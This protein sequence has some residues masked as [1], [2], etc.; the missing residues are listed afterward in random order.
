MKQQQAGVF[1]RQGLAF[2]WRKRGDFISLLQSVGSAGGKAGA[3]RL[4]R[5]CLAETEGD[6]AVDV[7]KLIEKAREAAERRNYDY[8][9]DLYL[10]ALKLAPDTGVARRE[11][12]AVENRQAKEKGTSMWGKAKTAGMIAQ[13]HALYTCKKYDSA[14]EKAEDALKV[15]PSNISAMMLLGKAALDAGYSDSA[16]TTFEDIKAMNAGGNQKQLT[17]ALRELAHAYEAKGRIKEAMDTWGSVMKLSPGDREGS[18]KIRDLS[19]KTMTA[20]IETSA[21]SGRAGAVARATQSEE[22]KAQTDR[23]DR[24][25]GIDIKTAEDLKAV[26]DDTKS[27]IEKRPDDARLWAKLGDLHKQG[28]SY[29]DAKKAFEMAREKDPNNPSW[30][31]RSHDLEIWKMEG[32]IRALN[33]KLKAGDAGVKPQLHKDQLALLEYKL[34][35]FLEREKQYSTESRIR[36]EL[37]VVYYQLAQVKNDRTL[38][39]ECIKRFQFTFQDPK[40][41]RE[42]GLRMGRAFSAKAQYE[43]ALK[44]F[45]ETLR[46]SELKDA[47]WKD[48][49]YEKGDTLQKSG[50]REEARRVFTEIY[51]IDVSYKD[52][53]KRVEDLGQTV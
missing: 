53:S 52:V 49:M 2:D 22:Q 50:Q 40:Y 9:I 47:M 35:S 23:L 1:G 12:R 32:S 24:E 30:L 10:Q 33:A 42:S 5:T 16:V 39:D 36:Y 38:Y 31:F 29:V 43:L 18:V 20:Q 44:R 6:A 19:A 41:R 46:L 13:T 26:I 27:D 37:G 45:D 25:K 7:S 4:L 8:A 14:I 3:R 48:L 11:L 51:E 21:A 34:A 28:N 15:D 17:A